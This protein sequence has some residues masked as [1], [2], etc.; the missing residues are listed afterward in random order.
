MKQTDPVTDTQAAEAIES[1]DDCARMTIG[2]DPSGPREV[3]YR[4]VE[5]ARSVAAE[6]ERLREE[7]RQVARQIVDND[8][9]GAVKWA[10]GLMTSLDDDMHVE[11]IPACWIDGGD[12]DQLAQ[13]GMGG[14]LGWADDGGDPR[15]VPVYR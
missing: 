12:L 14:V 4:Y 15:R 5:Q 10:K 7:N 13:Y 9:A 8:Q 1:M 2:V 3:L 6:L 11:R